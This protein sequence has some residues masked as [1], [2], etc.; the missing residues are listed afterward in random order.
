M[1]IL[2]IEYRYKVLLRLLK[3]KENFVNASSKS[4]LNIHQA[5]TYLKHIK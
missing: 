3:T 1:T 4:G 2:T 5:A